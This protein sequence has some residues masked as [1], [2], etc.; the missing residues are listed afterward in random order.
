MSLRKGAPLESAARSVD[1]A[2]STLR[3]WMA[4]DE[5]LANQVYQAQAACELDDLDVIDDAI[6]GPDKK[7]AVTTAQW[8]RER[9][10]PAVWGRVSRNDAYTRDQLIRAKVQELRSEGIEITE[11]ELRR[12]LTRLEQKALPGAN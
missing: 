11:E 3:R 7:L 2:P 4:E 10:N 9:L 8:R 6:K 5:D 1:I 12:E